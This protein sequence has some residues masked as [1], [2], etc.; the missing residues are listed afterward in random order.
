MAETKARNALERKKMAKALEEK[1]RRSPEIL[2]RGKRIRT[3]VDYRQLDNE[4]VVKMEKS[5]T[6]DPN[7]EEIETELN[8]NDEEIMANLRKRYSGKTKR[9]KMAFRDFLK[10]LDAETK[11]KIRVK[12]SR[13]F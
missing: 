8:E 1:A 7:Y 12:K 4:A 10:N 5:D 13:R 2:G 9:N 6:E 11:E 3:L